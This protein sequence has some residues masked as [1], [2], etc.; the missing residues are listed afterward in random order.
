MEAR[1]GPH[2][3]S[4]CGCR[5]RYR[6][7]KAGHFPRQRSAEVICVAKGS[8]IR[9]VRIEFVVAPGMWRSRGMGHHREASLWWGR[10]A[11]CFC[12]MSSMVT[13]SSK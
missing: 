5:E 4:S 13:T 7:G 11:R 12:S 1:A 9:G 6:F 3:L 2:L 10:R 8:A